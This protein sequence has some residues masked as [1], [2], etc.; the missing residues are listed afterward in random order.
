V[1]SG[2]ERFTVNDLHELSELVA[3]NWTAAADRDWTIPAASTGWSCLATADHA[4]DCVYAPAFFLASR[5]LDAY[6]LAGSNLELGA[7]ATPEELVESLAIATRI[8]AAVVNDAP[9]NARAIIFRRPHV[10]IGSAPDFVPRAALELILHA[11]DVAAGLG[12]AF[13]PGEGLCRR[14]RE[15]TRPW[16]LWTL[17]WNGLAETDDP[18]GDLLAG[19]GRTRAGSITDRR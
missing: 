17:D 1:Q 2:V 14:L 7:D 12:L 5:K 9:A 11:N 8:T 10:L 3:S 15:H 16:P 6:P 19:S 13:E 4:V 18:W